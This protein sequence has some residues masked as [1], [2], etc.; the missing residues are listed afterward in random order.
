LQIKKLKV[1]YQ[2]NV[3]IFLLPYYMIDNLFAKVSVLLNS[4][5]AII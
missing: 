5:L 4:Y 1:I 2:I 3:Y